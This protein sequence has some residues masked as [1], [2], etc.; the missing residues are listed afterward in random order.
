[1]REPKRIIT[2]LEACDEAAL[3]LK[4]AGFVVK[5]V[6]MRSEAVYFKYP[7]MH[8]VIRVADHG[9]G[10]GGGNLGLVGHDEIHARLTFLPDKKRAAAGTLVITEES[11]CN[12]VYM[13]IGRYMVA[14]ERPERRNYRG[15]KVVAA[16]KGA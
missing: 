9:P 13:A 15:P 16:M 11:V 12:M 3:I 6:S 14:Q 2:T 4:R 8:G 5:N 7:G 10:T 1:M